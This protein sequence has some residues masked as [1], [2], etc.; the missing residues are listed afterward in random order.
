M[1][2]GG[3]EDENETTPEALPTTKNTQKSNRRI[4]AYAAFAIAVLV[5]AVLVAVFR[6][7]LYKW[8]K[9]FTKEEVP[10]DALPTEV[11]NLRVLSKN[12]SSVSVAW[13]R[14]TAVFEVYKVIFHTSGT[15][16]GTCLNETILNHTETQI[17]CEGLE[18]CTTLNITVFTQN[19]SSSPE[20]SAGVTLSNI[21]VPGKDPGPPMDIKH[22]PKDPRKTMLHWTAP[23]LVW[24][25]L[26]PYKVTVCANPDSCPSSLQVDCPEYET[27]NTN[28]VLNT[29]PV[30]DYCVVIHSTASCSNQ[31]HKSQAAV[32][33]FK[34]PAFAPGNFTVT[35]TATSPSS[36]RLLIGPPKEKNGNL[37]GC[38]AQCL[39]SG[40]KYDINCTPDDV[41]IEVKGLI[42][43]SQYTCRVTFYNNHEGQRLE[44]TEEDGARTPNRAEQES[45]YL[46]LTFLMLFIYYFH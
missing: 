39:S 21:Q 17:T 2:T 36:I 45:S 11:T 42:P 10:L 19:S 25:S 29:K 3:D 41:D 37:D 13:D 12:S 32:K 30:T 24:G 14:P 20:V 18:S 44:T 7:P 38:S 23:Q 16:I 15:R 26:G 1:S 22:D 27:S 9:S 6:A 4:Y 43:S 31:V 34:T 33:D 28:L 35:A 8:L 46:R 40:K 5:I